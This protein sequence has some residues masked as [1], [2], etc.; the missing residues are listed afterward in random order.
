VTREL[1][2]QVA[3]EKAQEL[4]PFFGPE[5]P[6]HHPILYFDWAV[7]VD[8]EGYPNIFTAEG[9]SNSWVISGNYTKSG[10]PILRFGGIALLLVVAVHLIFVF[11]EKQ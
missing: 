1:L 7:P 10:K 6:T 5:M 3:S 4:E 11:F 8:E 2:Y 9:G